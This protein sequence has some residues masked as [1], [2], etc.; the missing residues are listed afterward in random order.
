MYR[1]LGHWLVITLWHSSGKDTRI[2]LQS[3]SRIFISAFI[4]NCNEIKLHFQVNFKPHY[5]NSTFDQGSK[6]IRSMSPYPKKPRSFPR[7]PDYLCF[8]L[9]SSAFHSSRHFLHY[10]KTRERT[11]PFRKQKFFFCV[12][13]IKLRVQG[14]RHNDC[15]VLISTAFFLIKF[16]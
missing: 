3:W 1:A 5:V 9:P 8:A 15:S 12:L 7:K 16:V 14:E 4:K 2:F 11:S 13:V 10:I 6:L